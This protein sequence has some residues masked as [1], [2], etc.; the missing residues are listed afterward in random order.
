MNVSCVFRVPA[1]RLPRAIRWWNDPEVLAG[2]P[3]QVGKVDTDDDEDM[4]IHTTSGHMPKTV[5]G[6]YE[7]AG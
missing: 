6:G 7:S 3:G 5:R 1:L 4:G 2:H